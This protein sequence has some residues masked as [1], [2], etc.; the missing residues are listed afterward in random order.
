M[1]AEPTMSHK[2]MSHNHVT[3]VHVGLTPYL[4]EELGGGTIAMSPPF[5]PLPT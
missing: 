1:H 5:I 3:Q 2:S 4:N